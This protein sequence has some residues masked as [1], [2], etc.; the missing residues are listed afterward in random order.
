[1]VAEIVSEVHDDVRQSTP[2][3]STL[4]RGVPEMGLPD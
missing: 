4:P 1:M 2:V 3:E